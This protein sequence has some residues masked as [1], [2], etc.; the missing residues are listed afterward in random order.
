MKSRCPYE[1]CRK[2]LSSKFNL[3][4][5]IDTCHLR[6][7]RFECEV[8]FKRFASKQNLREH[9]F[10]HGTEAA[11]ST[12][13]PELLTGLREEIVIPKL[14]V[15]LSYSHDPLFRPYLHVNR[16]YPYPVVAKEVQLVPIGKIAREGALPKFQDVMQI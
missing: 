3:Q 11:D 8:C 10:I 4:R 9:E 2:S 1:D 7:K 6:I 14:S 5:H 13:V 16:I 12:E 15:L